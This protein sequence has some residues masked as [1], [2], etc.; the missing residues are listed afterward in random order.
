MSNSTTNT[1]RRRICLALPLAVLAQT[2]P[3]AAHARHWPP[4]GAL[5][6][7]RH[8]SFEVSLK[9]DL[10]GETSRQVVL[11]NDM[12]RT[13]LRGIH[14]DTPWSMEFSIA[15]LH[16]T[17]SLRVDTRLMS[18]DQMLAAPV[19]TAVIGQRVVVRADDDINVALVIRSA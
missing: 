17:D 8:G 5:F 15:R 7:P 12:Q 19:R 9:L 11:V 14:G 16:R 3:G 6:A 4:R 13:I 2:V 1:L 18:G 10:F